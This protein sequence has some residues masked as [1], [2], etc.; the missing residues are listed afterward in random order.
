MEKRRKQLEEENKENK[1]N[2]SMNP[3]D[4]EYLKL[5]EEVEKIREEIQTLKTKRPTAQNR[6]DTPLTR[7]QTSKG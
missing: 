4:E 2:A 1:L 5:K 7:S 6:V 3:K